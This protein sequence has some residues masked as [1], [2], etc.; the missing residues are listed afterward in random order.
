MPSILFSNMI[1]IFSRSS[2]VGFLSFQF[3]SINAEVSALT[4]STPIS[5][6]VI[7]F[8]MFVWM[9]SLVR[10]RFFPVGL[11]CRASTCIVALS[12]VRRTVS[13]SFLLH[14]Q[15]VLRTPF[16]SVTVYAPIAPTFPMISVLPLSEKS[17]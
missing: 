14:R 11:S 15:R 12:Q 8:M 1:F 16:A 9:L 2:E 17:G 4:F 5:L 7:V 13:S 3:S 10:G 6:P